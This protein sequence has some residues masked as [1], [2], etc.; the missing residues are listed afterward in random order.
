MLCKQYP[1][2]GTA[3]SLFQKGL[4]NL[5]HLLS[6]KETEIIQQIAIEHRG[7]QIGYFNAMHVFALLE[8]F[9]RKGR[10]FSEEEE[11]VEILGALCF[12]PAFL[13]LRL[14]GSEALG[15][16]KFTLLG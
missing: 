5:S 6:P 4:E 1:P 16:N 13:Q 9:K 7:D 2:Y 12:D 3:N 15:L 14:E 11:E 10:I 8:G